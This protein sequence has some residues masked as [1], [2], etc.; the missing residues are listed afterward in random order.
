MA[1]PWQALSR[2]TSSKIEHR[3][4]SGIR[5]PAYGQVE[6][7][8]RYANFSDESIKD[9]WSDTR[10]PDMRYLL[11]VPSIWHCTTFDAGSISIGAHMTTSGWSQCACACDIRLWESKMFRILALYAVTW[12]AEKVCDGSIRTVVD[13]QR[14]SQQD[15]YCLSKLPGTRP[16]KSKL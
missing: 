3:S 7:K 11:K 4:H 2:L 15:P 13:P 16:F 6:C 9:R 12:R 14:A 8:L 5:R 10:L 1:T